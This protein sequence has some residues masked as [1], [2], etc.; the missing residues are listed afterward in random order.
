ML[1]FQSIYLLICFRKQNITPERFE[2]LILN[3]NNIFYIIS[4]QSTKTLIN[5]YLIVDFAKYK[6]FSPF[7]VE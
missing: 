1:H 4:S 5:L 3:F 7:N 6:I 2:I